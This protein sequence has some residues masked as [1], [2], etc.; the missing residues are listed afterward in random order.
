MQTSF[1]E[2]LQIW[3]IVKIEFRGL[4]FFHI[5]LLHYYSTF[6][7]K[8]FS[9]P[10]SHVFTFG[11]ASF[12]NNYTSRGILALSCIKTWHI[13]TIV[14]LALGLRP[15][16]GLARVRAKREAQESH[17]MLPRV[18]ESE[19]E[20]SHSQMSSHFGSWSPGGLPDL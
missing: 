14:T 19:N 11:F 15:R 9:S 13:A 1:L 6:H 17:L 7:L 5:Y 16:Q 18:W 10:S 20:N 8:N 2:T 12:D 4:N 3:K